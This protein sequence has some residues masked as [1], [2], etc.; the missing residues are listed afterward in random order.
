MINTPVIDD[1]KWAK[2]S[3]DS[4][5]GQII[6]DWKI[7]QDELHLNVTIPPNTTATVY[8]PG[9]SISVEPKAKFLKME[10]DRMLLFV[11]SGQYHFIAKLAR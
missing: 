9:K 1:L 3:Y 11:E 8:M 2:T 7:H 10:N 4:I 6:T 5:Q